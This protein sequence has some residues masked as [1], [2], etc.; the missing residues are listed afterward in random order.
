VEKLKITMGFEEGI[1]DICNQV[2]PVRLLMNDKKLVKIC[3]SCAKELGSISSAEV[4]E[5]YGKL[6]KAQP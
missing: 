6:S 2:K 1:C 5:K 3:E 4:L